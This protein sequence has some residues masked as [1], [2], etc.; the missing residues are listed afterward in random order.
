M[1]AFVGFVGWVSILMLEDNGGG[2]H[3]G[4]IESD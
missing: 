1:D 4:V 3:Q 2:T